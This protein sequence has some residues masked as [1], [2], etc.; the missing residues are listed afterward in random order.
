MVASL[1]LA[2]VAATA[3]APASLAIPI[4]D[5]GPFAG[6]FTSICSLPFAHAG[7][8]H[9][10]CNHTAISLGC[11]AVANTGATTDHVRLCRAD[12]LSGS[13]AG[14]TTEVSGRTYTCD[15]GAGTGRFR[16]RPSSFE[17]PVTFDVNL[18]VV[19]NSIVIS[20]SY[21]QVST[22]RTVVVRAH[23]P[24]VCAAVTASP[25]GYEGVINPV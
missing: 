10:S 9:Y 16:Y 8:G 24:A 17:A 25:A 13:T 18:I 12:L 4:V 7:G 19:G 23:V 2:V 21:T 6:G 3:M 22:G 20:G 1:P 11:A 15:N 5:A 14:D